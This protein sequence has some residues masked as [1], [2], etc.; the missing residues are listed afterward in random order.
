M[1]VIP[2]FSIFAIVF[3]LMSLLISCG[4][5][6]DKAES[7]IKNDTMPI[8]QTQTSE[9]IEARRPGFPGFEANRTV[10]GRDTAIL[11]IVTNRRF[12]QKAWMIYY[13][14][15]KERW[16]TLKWVGKGQNYKVIARHIF[17]G[18]NGIYGGASTSDAPQIYAGYSLDEGMTWKPYILYNVSFFCPSPDRR[19]RQYEILASL[20]PGAIESVSGI[21]IIIERKTTNFDGNEL[22]KTQAAGYCRALAQP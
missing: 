15:D 2:R 10:F 22:D 16:D 1:K 3:I 14:L 13:N 18:R 4:S 11:T 7:N 17:S 9:Q 8:D 6:Q 12:L 19:G 5:S 21:A 20:A